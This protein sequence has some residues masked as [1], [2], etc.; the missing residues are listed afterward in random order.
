MNQRQEVYQHRK[1]EHMDVVFM[2]V[3]DTFERNV[4][5]VGEE[6]LR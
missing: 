3:G 1:R 2:S 5:V 6:V 4:E